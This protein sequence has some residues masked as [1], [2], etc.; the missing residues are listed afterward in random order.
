MNTGSQAKERLQKEDLQVKQC[1]NHNDEDDKWLGG[2]S[3]S[4]VGM[5]LLMQSVSP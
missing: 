3:F 5:A 1:Y 4:P 2:S